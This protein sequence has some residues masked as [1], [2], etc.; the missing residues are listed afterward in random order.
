MPEL[1]TKL[2]A[3]FTQDQVEALNR[4]QESGS[5]HPFTCPDH[6][7]TS[8]V[9]T[10][11]G[12]TC[13]HRIMFEPGSRIASVQCDYTQNWAHKFM[14]DP[15]VLEERDAMLSAFFDGQ[16]HKRMGAAKMRAKNVT[17]DTRYD[18]VLGDVA[19]AV[20]DSNAEPWPNESIIPA[21]RYAKAALTE[22]RR[23]RI[24]AACEVM[25]DAYEKAAMG[26]GWVTN[27]LSRKPWHE[28]PDANKNTMRAAVSALFDHLGIEP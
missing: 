23:L 2:I 17:E 22:Y 16:L 25:H 28:V 8:L 26:A 14:A 9:A 19:Q 11:K 1:D 10:E 5:M 15:K 18:D 27:P 3:P 21:D 4:F 20:R 7:D 12:W 13:P 24:E 6:S